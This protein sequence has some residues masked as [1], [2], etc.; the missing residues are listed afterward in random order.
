LVE[1]VLDQRGQSVGIVGQRPHIRAR[2]VEE[3]A[4]RAKRGRDVGIALTVM[5]E[6]SGNVVQLDRSERREQLM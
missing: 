2:F 5:N 3:G 6:Q 4:A 1:R